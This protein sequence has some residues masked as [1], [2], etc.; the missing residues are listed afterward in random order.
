MLKNLGRKIKRAGK[1]LLKASRST[2]RGIAKGTGYVK[3]LIGK[4]DTY[5]GGL[6]TALI[7]SNPYGQAGLAGLEVA[8]AG[9][10]LLKNPN[11]AIKAGVQEGTKQLLM[12]QLQQ[13]AMR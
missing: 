8:D 9:A 11:T 4:A 7:A 2:G 5:T 10:N 3:K 12:H 13:Q 6:S 1:R